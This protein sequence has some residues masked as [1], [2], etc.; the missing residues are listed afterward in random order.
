MDGSCVACAARALAATLSAVHDD[1]TPSVWAP[2]D[3]KRADK[4]LALPRAVAWWAVHS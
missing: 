4:K 3:Q 1:I 2:I